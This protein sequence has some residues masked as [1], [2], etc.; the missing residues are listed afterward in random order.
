MCI[1]HTRWLTGCRHIVVLRKHRFYRL[2]LMDE[3]GGVYTA[4]QLTPQFQAIMDADATEGSRPEH[5]LGILTAY[6]CN[7]QDT[8]SCCDATHASGV[9]GGC[10]LRCSVDRDTW[11]RNYAE[12]RDYHKANEAFLEVR[13]GLAWARSYLYPSTAAGLPVQWPWLPPPPTRISSPP[14]S[15]CAWT[16][17]CRA[18][19]MRL[20]TSTSWVAVST[21]RGLE[22]R[23]TWTAWHGRQ[24]PC[25]AGS[26]CVL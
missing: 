25:V 19:A 6:V 24:W 15:S 26:L 23:L 10:L 11:A 7:K 13:G 12:F 3:H 17:V 18:P 9:D 14:C 8:H 2:E 21:Q 1:H 20:L 5:G 4:S 22:T 16:R